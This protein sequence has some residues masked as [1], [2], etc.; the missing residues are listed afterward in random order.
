MLSRGSTVALVVVAV[1]AR[2]VCLRDII[3]FEAPALRVLVN[4]SIGRPVVARGDL[5]SIALKRDL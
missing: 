3:S 4:G 5:W 1:V 2:H